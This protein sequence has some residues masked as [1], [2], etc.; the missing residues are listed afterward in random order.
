VR[1]LLAFIA[2]WLLTGIWLCWDE[3][4]AW[5]S[6][7]PVFVLGIYVS[8][9]DPLAALIPATLVGVA[10]GYGL[11]LPWWLRGLLAGGVSGSIVYLF[12]AN[13]KQVAP[14][15]VLAFSGLG[16]VLGWSAGPP[17]RRHRAEL[18]DEDEPPPS[19]SRRR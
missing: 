1:A 2:C 16:F 3:L 5:L 15:L 10:C 18:I 19:N 12:L 13:T 8:F 17:V 14:M 11:R 9:I 6:H 4:L 7:K